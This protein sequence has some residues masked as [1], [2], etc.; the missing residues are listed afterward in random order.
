M[1]TIGDLAILA[2]KDIGVLASNES[3]PAQDGADALAAINSLIDQ[4]AA[5]RLM[6][7]TV[8]RSTWTIVASTGQ[9]TVGSGADVN[10]ARP[11]FL[12]DQAVR[13]QDTSLSP[14][15]EYK[16]KKLTEHG[17]QQVPL[18]TQESDQPS[19]W[20]YNPTFANAT[21]DLW[22]VPTSSTLEGVI[23]HPTA[24]SEFAALTTAV[25][26]PP[27]YRRMIVKNL[28]MELAP[29]YGQAVNPLLMTQAR[30]SKAR[31]K[32]ANTELNEMDFEH[33]AQIGNDRAIG[34]DI[35]DN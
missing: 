25:S 31:V 27:G 4:W 19:W 34:Y 7:Y 8:T 24:V 10:I 26:L 17:W 22:P 15:T 28:A 33:A 9:Y 23:Y 32:E 35:R 14:T 13:Y 11:V 3:M 20:Y 16:L 30:E 18:K 1:A 2:L 12:D 29:S 6:I 21:L 5:E